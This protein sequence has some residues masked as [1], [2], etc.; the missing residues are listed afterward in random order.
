MFASG[1]TTKGIVRP[2][3][4]PWCAVP[5]G[6]TA[7]SLSKR[8]CSVTVSTSSSVFWVNI[9]VTNSVQH[10]SH[11]FLFYNKG[12]RVGELHGNLSQPQRLEA[13]RKFKVLDLNLKNK[14]F[15][16]VSLNFRKKISI[17]W[18]LRTWQPEDLTFQAS[19]RSSISRCLRRSSATFTEW[20]VQPVQAALECPSP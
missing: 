11:V 6:I 20:V 4:A 3:C 13:L 12:V 9:C 5:S 2:S 17:F 14:T 8:N 16:Q 10:H 19:R 1:R 15:F 7:W 18:Y